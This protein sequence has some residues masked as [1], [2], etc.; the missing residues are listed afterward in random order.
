M[1]EAALAR[2]RFQLTAAEIERFRLVASDAAQAV[3]QLART[4]V[5][6]ET[7][8]EIARRVAAALAEH[9]LHAVVNL[10]AADERIQKYRHP[11]PTDRRWE[12]LVMIVV[13]ARRGGLIASFTRIV[14]SGDIPDELRRRTLATARVNAQ[15]MAATLPSASGAELYPGCGAH[16]RR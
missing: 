14:S 9:Q 10:V 1:I 4:L 5:P 12:K 6:G 3:A 11:V 8:R 7:E 13:C 15:L 2:C 16:L